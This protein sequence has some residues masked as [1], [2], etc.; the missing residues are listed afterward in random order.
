MA[1]AA[2][3]FNRAG[4]G[5]ASWSKSRT[6]HELTRAHVCVYTH[7]RVRLVFPGVI[8]QENEHRFITSSKAEHST[9]YASPLK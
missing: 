6:V 2:S 8:N 7:T 1:S 5:E 3:Y 9:L 4:R